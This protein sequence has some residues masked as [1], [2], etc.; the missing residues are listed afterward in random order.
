MISTVRLAL[1]A[2]FVALAPAGAA[3]SGAVEC[4]PDK[5][6][7]SRVQKVGVQGG[8]AVGWKTYRETIPLAD[9]EVILTFDDGPDP[10]TTPKVLEAL[11]DHCVRATFFA[12]GRNADEF[13]KLMR[14]EVEEGH[15]VAFHTYSHPQPTLRYMSDAAARADI[16]KGMIA[17]ER[18]A[19]AQDFSKGE[20][21]DL[22][23]LKLHAP[24]FRFPGFADTA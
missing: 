4:G 19:Y 1:L 20:P 16:L 10:Q 18:N 2:A 24:F 13:P 8:L 3:E 23:K 7:V 21:D 6:G 11:R 9:H 15:N 5:L 17:V 12:I 22:A 14:R